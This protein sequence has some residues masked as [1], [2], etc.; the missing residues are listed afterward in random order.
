MLP[1]LSVTSTVTVVGIPTLKNPPAAG[2]ELTLWIPQLSVDA[3]KVYI[4]A[5]PQSP[6][7]LSITIFA[8]QTAT[9]ASLSDTVT[10][11]V[12][13]FVLPEPSSA[14]TVTVVGPNGNVDPD[15]KSALE[16]TEQLSDDAGKV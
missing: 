3:G 7:S 15:A 12:Q 16:V 11:K 9:G 4:N 14:V 8:G 5:P 13:I 1:E 10:S 6:G 2:L